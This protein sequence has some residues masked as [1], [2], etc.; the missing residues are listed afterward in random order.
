[1]QTSIIL[2]KDE[3]EILKLYCKNHGMTLKGLFLLGAKKI[4]EENE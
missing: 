3:W 2:N 4:M 1:M